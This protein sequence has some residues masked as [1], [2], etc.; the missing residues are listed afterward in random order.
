VVTAVTP[1]FARLDPAQQEMPDGR[2]NEEDQQV[3]EICAETGRQEGGEGQ[4]ESA[5]GGRA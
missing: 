5:A 2:F 4:G 1:V 3:E